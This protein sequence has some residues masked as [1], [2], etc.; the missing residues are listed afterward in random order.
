MAIHIVIYG[1]LVLG[2]RWYS[3]HRLTVEVN[4]LD[5]VHR[6]VQNGI[7]KG[8]VTEFGMPLAGG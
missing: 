8:I 4:A 2:V 5:V 7:G 1:A 6:A 3:A